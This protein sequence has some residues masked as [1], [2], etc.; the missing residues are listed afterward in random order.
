MG[1]FCEPTRAV[2]HSPGRL[3]KTAPKSV[4]ATTDSVGRDACGSTLA[5]SLTVV[6]RRPGHGAEPDPNG[7]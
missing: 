7:G 5:G 3:Q 6:R 2:W 4:A 1:H